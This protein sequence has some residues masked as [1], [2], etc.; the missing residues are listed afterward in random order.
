MQAFSWLQTSCLC[1]DYLTR[2]QL[3]RLLT[4]MSFNINF[5][6]LSFSCQGLLQHRGSTCTT[7]AWL[8]A[9]VMA[10]QDK[11]RPWQAIVF[12]QRR[13]AAY[14]LWKLLSSCPSLDFLRCTILMGSGGTLESA[15]QTAQ[16]RLYQQP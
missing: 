4:R 10:S 3:S 16:V 6:S 9:A 15:T 1:L 14:A 2:L 5:C 11:Q 8:Q 13:M 7:D 12:V